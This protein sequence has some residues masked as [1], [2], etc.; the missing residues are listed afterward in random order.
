MDKLLTQKQEEI[1][2]EQ[3]RERDYDKKIE[4]EE[5]RRCMRFDDDIEEDE[6]EDLRKNK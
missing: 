6:E 5:Q 3:A 1:I 2:L 4:R